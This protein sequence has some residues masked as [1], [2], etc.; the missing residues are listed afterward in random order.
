MWPPVA[1]RSPASI[2][3]QEVRRAAVGC[4]VPLTTTSARSDLT[5]DIYT[6]HAHSHTL[7]SSN[8]Q[9]SQIEKKNIL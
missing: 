6:S 1:P 9:T 8:T 2:L 3:G 4:A 7:H 5:C